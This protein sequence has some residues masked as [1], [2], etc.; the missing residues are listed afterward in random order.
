MCYRL[1]KLPKKADRRNIHL[2][3][4]LKTD[5]LP[6]LR[7]PYDIDDS[8]ANMIDTNMYKNDTLGDCVIAGRGH[9]TL[10]FEDFEQD[11]IIPITD[12]DVVIE[13]FKESGGQDNGL[14]MLDSLNAW[15]H[16]WQAADKTYSI[17][18]YAD[19]N[20]LDHQE[21]MYAVYLLQG[22]YAGVQL[23]IW[24]I[25]Q[26][27]AGNPWTYNA[28]DSIIGGHCIYIVA[29]NEI[30]PICITWGARQQMTWEFWNHYCDEAYAVIDNIDDWVDPTT[31]PL[32]I[33]KLQNILN[34]ITNIPPDTI[35]GVSVSIVDNTS[36]V[37]PNA[38]VQVMLPD[39]TPELVTT[40]GIDGV[41]NFAGLTIGN[42]YLFIVEYEAKDFSATKPVLKKVTLSSSDPTTTNLVL[43]IDFNL[44]ATIQTGHVQ[45][46]PVSLFVKFLKRLHRNK[47][48]Q[49]ISNKLTS[50]Y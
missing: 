17:Y 33:V 45:T 2:K 42:T 16:G 5:L 13:Y 11:I 37:V 14:V 1:G 23:P 9:M 35:T 39:F 8:F 3:G 10:R 30:G 21:V 49:Y 12:D 4:L 46:S 29:Y 27:M 15:R 48:T 7:I 38:S 41:A 36:A 19:I 47:T 18:A 34:I 50:M 44:A 26:F 28:G 25:A 24:A 32:D 22:V 31:D 40:S 43:Q 20:P 6:P